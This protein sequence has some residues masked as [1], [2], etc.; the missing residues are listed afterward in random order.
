VIQA[1]FKR[2]VID[3]DTVKQ[4]FKT[5]SSTAGDYTKETMGLMDHHW[6]MFMDHY[7][8]GTSLTPEAIEYVE[9]HREETRKRSNSK[10]K[11]K[12]SH[13]L[14]TYEEFLQHPIFDIDKKMDPNTKNGFYHAMLNA[15]E[16][17]KDRQD[18]ERKYLYANPGVRFT[19]EHLYKLRLG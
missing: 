8:I 6:L 10:H 5:Y 9:Q 11:V 13:T 19:E 18:K 14:I 1:H 15:I 7:F 16:F 17:D 12:V 3:L 4:M 2:G